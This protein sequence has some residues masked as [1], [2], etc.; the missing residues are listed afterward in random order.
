MLLS[1]SEML[2]YQL[3]GSQLWI[4]LPLK[5]GGQGGQSPPRFSQVMNIN[6][7]HAQSFMRFT[8]T[9]VTVQT[10]EPGAPV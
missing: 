8:S 1:C 10:T 5:R 2:T 4:A 3:L 7:S 9:G 6:H